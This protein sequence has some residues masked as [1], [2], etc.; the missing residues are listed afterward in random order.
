MTETIVL[1]CT[2]CGGKRLKCRAAADRSWLRV[3]EDDGRATL[4]WRMYL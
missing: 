3:H 2:G 4:Q 1:G